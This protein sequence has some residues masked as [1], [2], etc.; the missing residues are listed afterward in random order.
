M[1]GIGSV[2]KSQV[3]GFVGQLTMDTGHLSNV[4]SV[5][6]GGSAQDFQECVDNTFS[7]LQGVGVLEWIIA[8]KSI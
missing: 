3:F 7:P 5:A 2:K 1:N 8:V 6:N 4:Q